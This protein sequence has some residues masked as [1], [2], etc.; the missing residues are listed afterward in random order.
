ME[1]EHD[2]RGKNGKMT[3]KKFHESC[4]RQNVVVVSLREDDPILFFLILLMSMQEEN[5]GLREDDSILFLLI[6]LMSMQEENGGLR[7]DEGLREDDPILFL[8]I[9]LMSMQE[10]N[11]GFGWLKLSQSNLL[12]F[13]RLYLANFL[14][15]TRILPFEG[16]GRGKEERRKG[17]NNIFH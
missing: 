17:K 9:L 11:G 7:E 2:G 6:L 8:L 14:S 10:E 15:L 5:G 4:L 16:K 13:V 12:L 3:R 1:T